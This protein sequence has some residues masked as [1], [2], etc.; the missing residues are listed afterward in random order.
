MN[1]KRLLR[2]E[3]EINRV[4]SNTIYNGIKDNRIDPSITNITKIKLTDDLGICYVSVAV[5]GDE[6]IKEKTIKGLEH[7]TGFMKRKI[8][9]TLDLR[10]TP[11]LIFKLDESFEKGM[12]LSKLITKVSKEDREKRE[13]YA[14]NEEEK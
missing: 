6:K 1:K 10:H 13:F 5:F 14:N 12:L 3:S 8:S 9:Q 7:A 2:I 11:K 4:L